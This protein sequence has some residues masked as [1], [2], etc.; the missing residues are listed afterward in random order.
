M[1]PLSDNVQ[2]TKLDK[3]HVL[4]HMP[5]F[6][7]FNDLNFWFNQ[8]IYSFKQIVMGDPLAGEDFHQQIRCAIL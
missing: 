2:Y 1:I 5:L 8:D 7:A 6:K 4:H 3:N